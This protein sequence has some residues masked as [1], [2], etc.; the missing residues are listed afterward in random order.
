MHGDYMTKLA[1]PQ[2]KAFYR[3]RITEASCSRKETVDIYILLTSRNGDRKIMHTTR[4]TNRPSLRKKKWNP[5]S[6]FR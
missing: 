5:L 2:R 6:Q 4:I 3:K 1:F